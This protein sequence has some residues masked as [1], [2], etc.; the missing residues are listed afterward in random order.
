MARVRRWVVKY[1]EK[2]AAAG[3]RWSGLQWEVDA[4]A[5]GEG[6]HKIMAFIRQTRGA[7][8]YSPHAQHMIYSA[9]SDLVL[10]G[11][12]LHEE[13]VRLL[14]EKPLYNADCDWYALDDSPILAL[15]LHI[16][17][18]SLTLYH[19]PYINPKVHPRR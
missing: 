5:P 6:E 9:D 11:L 15:N 16:M 7:E 8:G 13:N 14:A 4:E 1:A 2:R 17:H 19:Q 10:L 18:H 3:S 12:S